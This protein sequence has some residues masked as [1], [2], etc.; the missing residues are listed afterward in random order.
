MFCSLGGRSKSHVWIC[1]CVV[2]EAIQSCFMWISFAAE[3]GHIQGYLTAQQEISHS[4]TAR[5]ERRCT[6]MPAQSLVMNWKE[7]ALSSIWSYNIAP[8][9]HDVL[10]AE[11]RSIG[12]RH[13][14]VNPEIWIKESKTGFEYL[15][16][17]VDEVF[18]WSKDPA[19][20]RHQAELFL[21]SELGQS[22]FDTLLLCR[23]I[24]SH[25]CLLPCSLY[26][27]GS[28]PN[29]TVATYHISHERDRIHL[30]GTKRSA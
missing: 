6:E 30:Q 24:S 23:I 10:S 16:T 27:L 18:V 22:M 3:P 13:T 17:Y 21:I 1:D 7:S 5:Q 19:A 9:Y 15:T 2:Y 29:I 28:S 25:W 4:F 26:G 8:Q 11:L 14:K 20:F 12:F